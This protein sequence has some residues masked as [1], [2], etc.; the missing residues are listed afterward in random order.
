MLQ[1]KVVLAP[2]D[3]SALSRD[4]VE[5]AAA[6]AAKFSAALVLVHV[7]PALPKLPPDVSIFKEGEYERRLQD[8]AAKRVAEL[9]AKY[10]QTGLSVRSEVGVSND[11]AMEIVRIAERQKADL[12]VLGSHGVTGWNKLV[13]GSVA[14]KVVHAA[15]C[16]VLVQKVAPVDK[17]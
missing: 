5:T 8:D 12:I 3:F 17:G 14:E 6:L 13:F 10:T 4:A 2:I 15:H 1:T 9:V 11:V 16:A 7:V